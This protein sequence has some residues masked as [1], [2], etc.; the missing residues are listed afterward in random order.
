LKLLSSELPRV[1]VSACLL[2]ERVRY[3]G[4]SRP[5]VW[6][7]D[8]LS[9]HAQLLPFCP[10]TGAGQG[11]PRPPV[12]LV[13]LKS[14]E[15]RVRGVHESALD[16]T[17]ILQQWSVRQAQYLS[18]LDALIFKSRS[19][20]CGL[21]STPLFDEHAQLLLSAGNGIFAEWVARNFPDLPVYDES[22]LETEDNRRGFLARIKKDSFR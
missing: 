22:R 15:I 11:T 13:R 6:V 16:V 14:G 12:Q 19:P 7:R 8:E 1:G 18:G 9:E 5:H 3:D 4:N 10:E 17:E 20:S 2:G 21:G